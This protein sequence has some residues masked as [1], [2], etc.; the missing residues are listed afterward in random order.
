M[1]PTIQLHSGVFFDYTKPDTWE[2]DIED[3]AH[4]LSMICRYT[5]HCSH[6]YSVAQHSVYVSHIVPQELAFEGLMHDAAEAY[7]GDVNKPLKMQLPE[8]QRIEDEVEH[9]LL[10]AF[11]IE[12]PLPPAIKR[13]DLQMLKVEKEALMRVQD[14]RRWYGD[15]YW[16]TVKD[17]E[18]PNIIIRP[19]DPRAAKDAFL[20]RF[21]H[22]LNE[23]RVH[24]LAGHC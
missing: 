12:L 10:T 24:D 16:T 4:A 21:Y 14:A 8:Y 6:F 3:I 5:G 22:L 23:R 13:A 19:L 11:G 15:D 2:F 7:I 1:K 18:D 17:V 9:A 20:Q